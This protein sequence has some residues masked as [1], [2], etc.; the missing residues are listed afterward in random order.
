MLCMSN[1]EEKPQVMIELQAWNKLSV[2]KC[3]FMTWPP[4]Q[5]SSSALIL[6]PSSLT[7]VILN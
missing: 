4:I 3:Y 5:V 1:L 6:D 2:V 7:G